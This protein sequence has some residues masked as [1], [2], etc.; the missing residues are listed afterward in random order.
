M[1]DDTLNPA[2]A[3]ILERYWRTPARPDADT[4]LSLRSFAETQVSSCRRP[5][6]R[7]ARRCVGRLRRNVRQTW[8]PPC[9]ADRYDAAASLTGAVA[10]IDTVVDALMRSPREDRAAAPA[11][12]RPPEQESR[13]VPQRR[14][15]M[16]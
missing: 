12:R 15:R 10:T 14:Q 13:A 1:A 16:R 3:A 6:C 7:R 5:R 4:T 8:M 2:A 11:A 9:L